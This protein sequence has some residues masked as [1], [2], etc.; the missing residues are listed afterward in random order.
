MAGCEPVPVYSKDPVKGP[1][2][3]ELQR[4]TDEAERKGIT[5]KMLLLTNP[6]NPLGTVYK[7]HDILDM[8]TWARSR[9]MHTIVDEIYALSM[10]KVR[11]LFF[12]SDGLIDYLVL[13][14]FWLTHIYETTN[15]VRIRML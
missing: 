15:N 4:A 1:T 10:H 7:P 3:E 12:T 13:I 14:I 5:V 2:I 9:G 11:R 6:N 8:I